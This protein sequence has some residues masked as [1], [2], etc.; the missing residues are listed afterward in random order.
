MPHRSGVSPSGAF[1]PFDLTRLL[2][3]VF[4]PTVG[5]RICILTD[6]ENP[7]EAFTGMRFMKNPGHPV[8]KKAVEVFLKSLANGT[9]RDLGM[10]GGEIFTCRTTHGSNLDMEDPCWDI[11]GK[12]L[13][14]DR[15]LIPPETPAGAAAPAPA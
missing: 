5:C 15:G 10:T 2:G 9:M 6:F 3:T 4:D 1:P 12:L 7:P 11:T 8:R 13:S 14:L